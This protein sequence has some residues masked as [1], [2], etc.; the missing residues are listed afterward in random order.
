MWSKTYRQRVKGVSPEHL[1]NV[2]IDVNYW[3]AWQDDLEFARL[4]GAFEVGNTFLLRP[5]GGPTVTIKIIR[6]EKGVNFT[7]LT[8]FPLAEM[9]GEHDFIVHGDE[10]EIKVT[11]SVRGPLAF[12]WSRVVAQG[13]VDDLPHQTQC[14]IER[15][16]KLAS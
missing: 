5:K 9:I 2:W 10:L 8:K 14:L 16:Q 4:E 6:A 11:M 1:W 7:D 13:I 3:A 12:L 15:A